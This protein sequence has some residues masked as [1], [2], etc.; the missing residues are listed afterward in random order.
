MM[1]VLSP[2]VELRVA[3]G[4]APPAPLEFADILPRQAKCV[5]DTGL[6][7]RLVTELLVKT[8][9]ASGKTP[10][11]A[12][13]GKL[14]LSVSVLREVLGALMA[15]QQVEVAWCGDSDI[16]VQYQL[17][18]IGQRAAAEYLAQSRYVGPAPVTLAA[19]CA[20][21]ERQSLRRPD[22]QRPGRAE[23]AALL[24]EDGLD[25]ALRDV[26]GAALHSPRALLLHGPSGAGKTT[27]ARRLAHLLQGAVALPYAILAG[28]H[29]IQYYD[30]Q[31]HQVPPPAP[32]QQEDRRSLDARW[33]ICQRPLVQLGCG[34][35]R[36]MLELRADPGA[37]VLRAPPH[38]LANNG[39]LLVDDV[40][41]Q[42]VPLPELLG[43]FIGPLDHGVDQ[44]V[45]PGGQAEAV[46]FD[47]TV[48]FATDRAPAAMFEPAF[49]RRIGYK[50]A[51]GA[52]SEASY[53]ALLRRECR[54]HGIEADE[55]GAARLLALHAQAARPLLAG[56][57]HELLGHIAD[58]ASFAGAAPR[59]SAASVEQA[60]DSM[61]A[62][63]ACASSGDPS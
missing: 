33:A 31:V 8:M 21:V 59:L 53:R 45:L 35:T 55:E 56:D 22:A 6:D 10:L 57:A 3:H 58:F 50:V 42:R 28:R 20:V 32:R 7:P 27:L 1:D 41:R 14:K 13:A 40:G 19:W 30:P 60:W 11:P 4:T 34:L 2:A 29:I 62:T 48:V 54:Q 26:L 15:E 18:T 36:E 25:P 24:A 12:L 5:A 47:A 23:L 9:H 46:P 52:L 39:L 61:F 43:R 37:G 38:L 16:D 51:L 44:L 63:C 17:T 49:L